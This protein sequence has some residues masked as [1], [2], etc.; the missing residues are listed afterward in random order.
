MTNSALLIIGASGDV[1]QGIVDA[2]LKS[3]RT[4]IAA[5]RSKEKLAAL[6]N[7][8]DENLHI[9]TGSVASE[10][11]A[12]ALWNEAAKIAPIGEVVISVNAPRDPV[13][14]R[15]TNAD[16]IADLFAGNVLTHYNAAKV[17]LPLL[18]DDG[19][20]I[21]I[22]GGMADFVFPTVVPVS[23]TQAA[24]RN[25]YRGLAKEYKGGA[26]VRELMIA[27]MVNG[28]SKAGQAEESWITNLECGQHLI[29]LLD[30]MDAFNAPVTVLKSRKQVGQADKD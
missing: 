13:M 25:L 3:G 17:I 28:P 30:N 19:K 5:A 12:L 10:D 18:P 27:S 21:G 6:P 23:M 2:A 16:A 7:A 4:V 11:D 29:A 15:D 9:I 20:Y 8:D 22:G 26:D 24:I 14:L 1:G